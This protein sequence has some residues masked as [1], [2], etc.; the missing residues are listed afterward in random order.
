MNV[1]IFE[2]VRWNACL[3]K[4]DL[5]LCSRSKEFWGNGVKTHVNSKGKI[6][7]IGGSEEGQT[8]DA[9]L[10]KTVSPTCYL[11]SYYSPD[12]M[13]VTGFMNAYPATNSRTQKLMF[14]MGE[15]TIW[16]YVQLLSIPYAVSRF[17]FVCICF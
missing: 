8:H 1:R 9:A 17:Y 7:S 6:P 10:C 3:S 13:L 2:S 12:L 11:L 4:L 15:V 14:I 16:G 5:S